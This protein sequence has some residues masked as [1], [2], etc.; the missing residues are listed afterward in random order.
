MVE[1]LVPVQYSELETDW[2]ETVNKGNLLDGVGN[3][4]DYQKILDTGEFE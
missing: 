4:S 1:E 3:I 2:E